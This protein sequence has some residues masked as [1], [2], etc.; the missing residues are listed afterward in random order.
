MKKVFVAIILFLLPTLVSA[1]DFAKQS[2]FL[3]QDSVTQGDSVLIHAVISN[4]ADSSFT[5]SLKFLDGK[6]SL[7]SISLSLSSKEAQVASI[8][9][10]PTAGSHTITAD[11]YDSNQLFLAEQQATFLVATPPSSTP[12]S[13]IESSQPIDTAIA[14]VSPTVAQAVVPTLS[15]IDSGRTSAAKALDSGII[16]AQAQIVQAKGTDS[17]G[18]VLSAETQKQVATTTTGTIAHTAGLTGAVI[19]LYVLSI[20]RYVV[21]NIGFFYPIVVILFFFVLWRMFRGLQRRRY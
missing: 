2:I 13:S 14:N 18:V 12:S 8:S 17:S 11:L 10:K 19:A 3:S 6:D 4:T 5:G 7:G 20:L 1:A 21:G 15:A 16:W 9:W